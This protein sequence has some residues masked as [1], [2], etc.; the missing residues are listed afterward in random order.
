[1]RVPDGDELRYLVYTTL[2][3]G[4][5]GISYYVYCWPKHEGG[6]AQ[7]DGTPTPL[8]QALKSLNREFAAIARELQPLTSL[9][10]YHAGMQPPGAVPLPGNAP[11]RFDPPVAPLAYQPPER[12]RGLVL[13]LFGPAGPTG[14]GDQPP[15]ATHAVVV[16]MDYRAEATATL[17][18]P[19]PCEV[20]DATAG[21]WSPASRSA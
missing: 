15:R 5:Q 13:G 17:V 21:R 1:M 11:F 18:G 2:A 3:Y 12:V 20:F 19:G 10:V 16:N 9:G 7:P 8:Y 6:I 4:A 14:S